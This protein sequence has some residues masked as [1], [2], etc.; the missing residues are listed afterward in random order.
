[1]GPIQRQTMGLWWR[2]SAFRRPHRRREASGSAQPPCTADIGIELL[3]DVTNDMIEI[4]D[5]LT[6]RFCAAVHNSEQG[7]EAWRVMGELL[8]V[9]LAV[10]NRTSA[11]GVI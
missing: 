3:I 5:R 11:D 8:A 9:L 7:P 6:A 1:M 10:L 4:Q 2:P